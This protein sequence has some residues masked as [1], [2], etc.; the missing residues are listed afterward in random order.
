MNRIFDNRILYTRAIVQSLLQ[1]N[2]GG[3]SLADVIQ[4][5]GEK[6]QII[7]SFVK[8]SQE[9]NSMKGINI[10]SPGEYSFRESSLEKRVIYDLMEDKIYELEAQKSIEYLNWELSSSVY[11]KPYE[12]LHLWLEPLLFSLRGNNRGN[13]NLFSYIEPEKLSTIISIILLNHSSKEPLWEEEKDLLSKDGHPYKDLAISLGHGI[14]L[15]LE[16]LFPLKYILRDEEEGAELIY[17]WKNFPLGNSRRKEY[18]LQKFPLLEYPEN[19]FTL[20]ILAREILSLNLSQSKNLENWGNVSFLHL[21]LG[22]IALDLGTEIIEGMTRLGYWTIKNLSKKLRKGKWNTQVMVEVSLTEVQTSWFLSLPRPSLS[23][24]AS[25]DKNWTFA[26]FLQKIRE[27]NIRKAGNLNAQYIP[28]GFNEKAKFHLKHYSLSINAEILATVCSKIFG[29]EGDSLLL[30]YYEIP[31]SDE[32]SPKIQNLKEQTLS[33]SSLKKDIDITGLEEL[34]IIAKGIINRRYQFVHA[35]KASLCLLGELHFSLPGLISKN[36]RYSFRGT[37]V[38]TQ[39]S[40]FQRLFLCVS[41]IDPRS[42]E[43]LHEGDVMDELIKDLRS[44]GGDEFT[45][46]LCIV[47]PE[48]YMEFFLENRDLIP[49][50]KRRKALSILPTMKALRDQA[51]EGENR[52]PFP[53]CIIYFDAPT[54]V[55][56]IQGLLLDNID[57]GLATGLWK[58]GL[59][60]KGFYR[61]ICE[62]ISKNVLCNLH[63]IFLE[64]RD[65]SWGEYQPDVSLEWTNQ[66]WIERSSKEICI[67]DHFSLQRCEDIGKRFEPWVKIFA[68]KL[69]FL[70]ATLS[71]MHF[72]KEL[73][74]RKDKIFWEETSLNIKIS[75]AIAMPL[76]YGITIFRMLKNVSEIR[77]KEEISNLLEISIPTLKTRE[78]MLLI[79]LLLLSIDFLYPQ[80]KDYVKF[81]EELSF[82][83]EKDKEALLLTTPSFQWYFSMPERKPFRLKIKGHSLQS[84]RHIPNTFDRKAFLRK[85]PACFLQAMDATLIFHSFSLVAQIDE[86]KIPLFPL[87]DSLGT[88]P[89]AG[90][91]AK[92]AYACALKK[93]RE[94]N[95]LYLLSEKYN[96]K[97]P[98]KLKDNYLLLSQEDISERVLKA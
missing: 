18:F 30:P 65:F 43:F 20:W 4:F 72:S 71:L 80:I 73:F 50:E 24:S 51:R 86:C 96:I 70:W 61:R 95:P 46:L 26:I 69:P 90:R 34:E 58:D 68:P 57:M 81:F 82:H 87:Y 16:T 48:S 84:F 45:E 1:E 52:I 91:Y 7:K 21:W 83:L 66:L 44:K 74:S 25:I 53:D 27:E 92:S 62:G 8:H 29:H 9:N 63:A 12:A 98:W 10:Y 11:R 78:N 3:P 94:E 55:Y 5:W 67:L 15:W 13:L 75:K 2:W 93:L 97:G 33:Y 28:K 60:F 41:W 19:I 36:G 39:G 59:E 79:N 40:L 32:F 23:P 89:G 31:E 14:L 35:V 85:V 42:R 6:S 54:S 76:S 38:N 77:Q 17:W 49:V 64:T 47:M 56:Q 22:E 37:L 88:L